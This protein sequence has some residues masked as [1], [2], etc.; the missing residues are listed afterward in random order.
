MKEI[1]IAT[2]NV[3][4]LRMRQEQLLNWL[5]I[6]QPDIV[7]LQEIK[8]ETAQF[9][10]LD[11]LQQGY[12]ATAIGQKSYNGVALL[13]KKE[14]GIPSQI[15]PEFFP[16]KERPEARWLAYSIPNLN[17]QIASL[18]VPNGQS[19]ENE[20][21]SYK[22]KWLSELK[23]YFAQG[24]LA[25]SSWVLAGDFNIA[26]ADI[27]V[28]DPEGFRQSVLCHPQ[29]RQH[30]E[31]LLKL[32]FKDMYREK[33][34]AESA[35]TYWDYRQLGFPKNHGLRIDHI[36]ASESVASR[37]IHVEIDREMRKGK[38]PSD[39]APVIA[40]FRLPNTLNAT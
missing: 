38:Q 31:E 20:K 32:G 33:K 9:P 22:N 40:T 23:D 25:S 5:I 39:H 27:D 1:K 17:I 12:W 11:F 28:Y 26:P 13:V 30:W 24:S 35:Y 16:C 29:V 21:F 10:A 19:V 8:M 3:N 14:L 7:C 18:Y 34:P 2:W 15:N 37:C 36:L 4:S 6:K